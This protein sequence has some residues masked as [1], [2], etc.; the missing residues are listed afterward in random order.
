MHIGVS[1]T[2]TYTDRTHRATRG[3]RSSPGPHADGHPIAVP[4]PAGQEDATAQEAQQTQGQQDATAQSSSR[5]PHISRSATATTRHSYASPKAYAK[6][7]LSTTQ[8]FCADAV[9]TRE[10]NWNPYATNPTSGAYGIAQALPARK[11]ASAGSDW[12]SNG[13]TQ[14]RWGLSYMKSRY[15]SPCGAWAF[16]QSRHWY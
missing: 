2:D 14:V 7:V 13:I 15:G 10:S 11:Y 8:F 6:S 4:Q 16:W 9:F 5:Y 12:R 3:R 1:G